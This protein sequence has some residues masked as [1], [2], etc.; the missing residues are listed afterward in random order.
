[1]TNMRVLK[2]QIHPKNTIREKYESLQRK[3]LLSHNHTYYIVLLQYH[4]ALK[5]AITSPYNTAKNVRLVFPCYI[6]FPCMYH[7]KQEVEVSH[8]LRGKLWSTTY[9]DATYNNQQR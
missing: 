8:I 3:E 7:H 9:M 5:C 1:M 2:G 6:Y 4:W